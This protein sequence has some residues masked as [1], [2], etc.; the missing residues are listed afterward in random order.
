MVVVSIGAACGG[1]DDSGGGVTSVADFQ[2]QAISLTC[3]KAFEC[4]TTAEIPMYFNPILGSITTVEDCERVY[5]GIFMTLVELEQQSI[6][7]GTLVFDSGKA[8][9]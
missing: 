5:G 9:S 8:S 2:A 3:V 6:D 1:D 4:C 7:A